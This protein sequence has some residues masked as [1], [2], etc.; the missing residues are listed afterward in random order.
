MGTSIFR[1]LQHVLNE[2]TPLAMVLLAS[3][4]VHVSTWRACCTPSARA[5]ATKEGDGGGQGSRIVHD[6]PLELGDVLTGPMLL[7]LPVAVGLVLLVMFWFGDIIGPLLIIL[8]SI[9]GVVTISFVLW[10]VVGR[11]GVGVAVQRS[12]LGLLAGSVVVVWLLTGSWIANDILAASL[13]ITAVSVLRIHSLKSI[14][15]LGIGLVVYVGLPSRL[16]K[17]RQRTSVAL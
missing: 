4:T 17:S 6:D 1:A 7:A 10:P 2:P 14:T 13:C 9:V 16:A 8:A 3:L 15:Q 5:D 12:L 11:L